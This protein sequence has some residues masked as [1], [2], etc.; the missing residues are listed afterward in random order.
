M[1]AESRA[2]SDENRLRILAMVDGQRPVS[3]VVAGV[4]LSQPLVSHHLRK[5]RLVGLVSVERQGPFVYYRVADARLPA[6]LEELGELAARL[7]A[8][9]EAT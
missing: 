2:L 8:A 6:L 3:Q 4:G 9:R 5:L 1:L 7:E